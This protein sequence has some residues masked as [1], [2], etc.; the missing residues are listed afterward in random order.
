[1]LLEFVQHADISCDFEIYVYCDR[2]LEFFRALADYGFNNA[3]LLACLDG[4]SFRLAEKAD[5][6]SRNVLVHYFWH[7]ITATFVFLEILVANL[8]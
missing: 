4:S 8:E 2:I 1:M 5:E 7:I 3:R 6:I